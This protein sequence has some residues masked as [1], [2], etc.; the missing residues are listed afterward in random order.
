[1][2]QAKIG[3]TVKVHYTARHETG[4]IIDTSQDREPLT[5]TLRSGDLIPGF[6]KGIVGM[7]VG[8]TKTIILP[9]EEAFGSWHEELVAHV[10]TRDLPLNTKPF[11]SKELTLEQPGGTYFYSDI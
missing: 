8:D 11:I 6:V 1:M 9:P 5:V 7:A 2:R 10:K 3:D 4:S